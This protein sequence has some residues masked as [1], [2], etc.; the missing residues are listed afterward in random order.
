MKKNKNQ[1]NQELE[2]KNIIED[3]YYSKMLK[4]IDGEL[5]FNKSLKKI[6]FIKKNDKLFLNKIS[7]ILLKNKLKKDQVNIKSFKSF[8][9]K[10]KIE[11]DIDNTYN[12]DNINLNR[13]SRIKRLSYLPKI[14]PFIYNNKTSIS[15]DYNKA[16]EMG[17]RG[18][19]RLCNNE[20]DTIKEILLA[21]N[22]HN[23]KN[24]EDYNSFIYFNKI[25]ERLNNINKN[26]INNTVNENENNIIAEYGYD[27]SEIKNIFDKNYIE[28]KKVSKL[29]KLLK[30][31]IERI[32]TQNKKVNKILEQYKKKYFNKD[33]A[34]RIYKINYNSIQKH[35][36]YTTLN[37][38]TKRIFPDNLINKHIVNTTSS[39]NL[40]IKDNKN[41]S[42]KI[43]KIKLKE[44]ISNKKL[45]SSMSFNNSSKN[46]KYFKIIVIK[47]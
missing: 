3:K 40:K 39:D 13:I 32:K 34:H 17:A 2:E 22:D 15:I 9:T 29:N 38:K 30:N 26:E 24:Y 31:K 44:N 5:T 42:K 25:N 23:F 28:K 36:P 6:K 8:S 12:T 19:R 10:N 43:K 4:N 1:I 37:T 47:N 35:I 14:S 16:S 46:G 45:C 7:N 18:F 21:Y 33:V 11:N 41:L 27:G 20:S